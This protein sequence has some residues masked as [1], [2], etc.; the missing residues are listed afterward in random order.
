M[1]GCLTHIG[2]GSLGR[3]YPLRGF[4][5]SSKCMAIICF[6]S[7]GIEMSPIP[8]TSLILHSHPTG[9]NLQSHHSLLLISI[10]GD[11]LKDLRFS[12]ASIML[13]P[14]LCVGWLTR[15]KALKI[16]A[17]Y[18]KINMNSEFRSM[19]VFHAEYVGVHR[20]NSSHMAKTRFSTFPRD[21]QQTLIEW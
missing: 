18:V 6:R 15:L 11:F 3:K 13:T 21:N 12:S 5:S 19:A 14:P 10:T 20:A 4:A 16:L 1:N 17:M 7:P 2:Y 9:E 8:D